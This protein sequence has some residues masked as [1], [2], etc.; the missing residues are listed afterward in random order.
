MKPYV[1]LA[2]LAAATL[3]AQI[4]T[5][6]TPPPQAPPPAQLTPETV[7]AK[8]DGKDV[9]MGE[10]RAMMQNNGDPRIM[11]A[12]QQNPKYVVQQLLMMRYLAGEADKIKLAERSPLKEQL[13]SIRMN[14]LAGAMVNQERDGYT[15]TQDS[16]KD[17]YEKN[18]ARY[19]QSKIKVIFI[20]FKHGAPAGAATPQSV[21]D[22]ARAAFESVHNPDV[23][24]ESEAK[25]IA[26]GLVARIRGGADFTSLVAESSDDPTSKAAAG[27]FGVVSST[28]PYPED[29]KKAVFALKV[30][31]VSDPVR[32]PNGFYIIRV[33][34]KSQQPMSEVTEAII[35]EIRQ[36]HL[37]DWMKDLTKRFEPVVQN[38]QFFQQPG[39]L[40][41][42]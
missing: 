28:S 22:A 33:E 35:Q 2:A 14:A 32:Q 38:Q 12:F 10:I 29:I 41:E 6:Q 27:D 40:T 25:T 42:K 17:F 13:E 26:A 5:A 31:D 4:P 36:S 34:E 18:Q 19:G 11:Q 30:G 21:E 7:V 1:L 24:P 3:A 39:R 23:R 8:V 16:I 15:V 9:T 37:N 20:K